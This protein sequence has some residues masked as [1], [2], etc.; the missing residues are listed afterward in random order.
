MQLSLFDTENGFSTEVTSGSLDTKNVVKKFQ[1]NFK[2]NKTSKYVFTDSTNNVYLNLNKVVDTFGDRDKN[3][4]D[5]KAI[6]FLD[7]L[8]ITLDKN[9]TIE[10]EITNLNNRTY[11]GLPYLYNTIKAMATL[12]NTKP[13]DKKIKDLIVKFKIDP[14]GVLKAGIPKNIIGT[15][16]SIFYK[17]G[18]KQ[19]TQIERIA[20]VQIN[21]GSGV[22]S[23]S[24]SNAAGD[25]VNEHTTDNTFTVIIDALNTAENRTDMYKA[26]SVLKYLEPKRNPMAKVS[27]VLKNLFQAAGPKKS[28]RS[29]STMFV[30][31]TQRTEVLKAYNTGNS[32]EAI[33]KFISAYKDAISNFIFQNYLSNMI[34]EKGNIVSVPT[35]FRKQQVK[36]NN[37]LKTD[38]EI[39]DGV[40]IVNEKRIRQDFNE[41]KYIATDNE[42]N[43]YS[44]REG[45]EAFTESNDVF[46]TEESYFKYVL[47]REYLFNKGLRGTEL[48]QE[49]LMNVFNYASIML[50]GKYSFTDQVLEVINKHKKT[51]SRG[52]GIIEQ[53]RGYVEK[54]DLNLLTLSDRDVLTGDTA[55]SYAT[56]LKALANPRIQKSC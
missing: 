32:S 5:D 19:N 22:T 53:I 49:A 31:G 46:P 45:L 26:G 8:G 48:N 47:E 7:A 12:E 54:S 25:R 52:Y 1:S 29:I 39:K 28:G 10:E 34:D 17:D 2:S 9:K 44:S 56:E 16:D 3:F 51:L 27:Q 50:P 40:F 14:V 11:Y 35:S 13:T 33:N 15:P 23:F 18:S 6:E 55:T 36:I 38:V 41:K 43:N 4:N 20:E 37:S 21:Y 24:S 30:S 42:V